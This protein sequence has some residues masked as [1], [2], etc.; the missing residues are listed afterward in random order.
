MGTGRQNCRACGS[1]GRIQIVVRDTCRA[2]GGAGYRSG[3]R[4]ANGVA[5]QLPCLIC[6]SRGWITRTRIAPCGSCD[7][8]GWI[9]C[10]ACNG[11]GICAACEG[12]GHKAPC[13]TCGDTGQITVYCP[14]CEGTGRCGDCRGTG[15]CGLC[16][17]SGLCSVCQGKGLTESLRFPV[18]STWLIQDRGYVLIEPDGTLNREA[19]ASGHVTFEDRGRPLSFIL[20]PDDVAVIVQND[21][22]DCRMLIRK[23]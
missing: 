10:G 1:T 13:A 3:L 14:R 16:H 4:N 15:K 20:K 23:P 8:N 9:T 18:M 19:G 2:C 17:G 21:P 11:A 5:A 12:K 7:G 6:R 22:A